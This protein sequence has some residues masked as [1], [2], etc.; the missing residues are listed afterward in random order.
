MKV[1]PS[2]SED[3]STAA[4]R[5]P[6]RLP[7]GRPRPG[8]RLRAVGAPH[9]RRER[10]R[11]CT[12]TWRRI[13]AFPESSRCSTG[14]TTSSTTGTTRTKATGRTSSSIFDARTRGEALGPSRC[15]RLQPARGRGAGDLGRRE[16]RARRRDAS[17]RSPRGRL[18]C[19]LLRRGAL[20]GQL[21][22]RASAATTRRGPTREI[23]PVVRTIPSDPR[24]RA[25]CFH[26]SGSRAL[27]RASE[28]VLQRA[29]R[30]EPQDSV[31]GA[32]RVSQDWRERSNGVPAG[33]AFGTGATDF[34]C[35]AV[36]G[37]S[38]ALRRSLVDQLRDSRS[39]RFSVVLVAHSSGSPARPGGRRRRSACAR[40]RR[41]VRSS[42]PR[43]AC[44]SRAAA[45][46]GIGLVLCRS[47]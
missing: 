3:L 39:A 24:R 15:R 8:V 1:A 29:D 44:T 13:R 32:D 11:P 25:P 21:G 14:S 7:R 41:G 40:R 31:D 43:R 17:R 19:E 46:L 9:H 36:G 6:P 18:A 26:G 45:V 5:V 47:R 30:A 16:A 34:F 28:G 22:R 2:A 12:R 33:G 35:G 37:G 42:P 38:N 10:R 27:G 20:P 23:R 4:L